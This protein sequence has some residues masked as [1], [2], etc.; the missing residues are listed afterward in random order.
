MITP[1]IQHFCKQLWKWREDSRLPEAMM[2]FRML[3]VALAKDVSAHENYDPSSDR[4]VSWSLEIIRQ[5]Q[6]GERTIRLEAAL[7]FLIGEQ[8]ADRPLICLT[9]KDYAAG[10]VRTA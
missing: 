3:S 6:I 1:A 10:E 7:E 2:I 8:L 4:R 9:G 5:R